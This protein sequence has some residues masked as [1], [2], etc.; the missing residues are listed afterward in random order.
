[1]KV[2]HDPSETIQKKIQTWDTPFVELDCFGTDNA[3]RI[4]EMMNDFCRNNL[5]S[6]IRGYLFYGS[7]VGSTHGIQLEDGRRIVIKARPPAE[8]N[9]YPKFD[10]ISLEAICNVMRWL[11]ARDYPCPR[12]ILGTLPLG[13]GLATVEEF[14]DVGNRGNGFDPVCRKN[15]RLWSSRVNRASTI[16]HW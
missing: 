8:T 1:M 16:F 2:V 5:G 15:N 3:E 11:A 6:N 13:N 7:S 10:R 4:A 12:P 14:M 9:P